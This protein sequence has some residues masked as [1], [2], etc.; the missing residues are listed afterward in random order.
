VK[1]EELIH[2]WGRDEIDT[3]KAVVLAK[4]RIAENNE[5]YS[6]HCEKIIELKDH[7]WTNWDDPESG[8][9]EFTLERDYLDFLTQEIVQLNSFLESVQNNKDKQSKYDEL[10]PMTWLGSQADLARIFTDLDKGGLIKITGR[11]FSK[12]FI[13]NDGE[14]MPVDFREARTT[15]QDEYSKSPAVLGVQQKIRG[16]RTESGE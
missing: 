2:S 15:N 9:T 11:D 16:M 12:H 5:Y 1:A 13:K 6:K 14:P 3:V 7:I 4:A 8:Y 10:V